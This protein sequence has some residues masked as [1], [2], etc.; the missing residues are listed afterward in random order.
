MKNENTANLPFNCNGCMRIL[1]KINELGSIINEQRQQISE[2]EDKIKSLE[3]SMDSKIE[4][5]VEKA[6]DMYRER[7]ERKCN[8]IIHNVPEPTTEDKKRE[9]EGKIREIFAVVKCEDINLKS[10]VRLGRPISGKS[11]L[12][13][14]ELDSVASKNK[15]LGGT[16][17]LRA[18]DGDGNVAHGWSNVFITPDLTKEER[19]KNKKLRVELGRRKEDEN[20]LNLIIYRGE[21]V[22]RRELS[23]RGAHGGP[24]NGH[25]PRSAH[26]D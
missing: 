17:W 25:V 10:V 23:R 12:M 1:P 22:D 19:D 16:R 18:K 4:N 24:G 9:D 20:N 3:A 8:I 2:Y 21:I 11:R 26:S 7:E 6:I 5:R 15:V 13:K 14:V